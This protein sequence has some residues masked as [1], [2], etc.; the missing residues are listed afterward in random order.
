MFL[1]E[2]GVVLATGSNEFN[3]IGLNNRQGFLMAMKNIFTKT[4][5]DGAMILTVVKSLS[6]FRIVDAA[7]GPTHVCIFILILIKFLLFPI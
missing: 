5:V 2:V 7:L 1:T 6:H 3:K 4:E